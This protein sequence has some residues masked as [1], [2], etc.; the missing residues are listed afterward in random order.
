MRTMPIQIWFFGFSLSILCHF[1][2]ACEVTITLTNDTIQVSGIAEPEMKFIAE[3]FQG[4]TKAIYS[5]HSN[6]IAIVAEIDRGE[7]QASYRWLTMDLSRENSVAIGEV[8][9]TTDR[10]AFESLSVMGDG[11]RLLLAD[12]TNIESS[13]TH[14]I[15]LY[16]N[17]CAIANDSPGHLQRF[18][19]RKTSA[20]QTQ[21]TDKLMLLEKD[22]PIGLKDFNLKNDTTS[23][24]DSPPER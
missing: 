16:Y 1:A 19:R 7:F 10:L 20:E 9:G 5:Y 14:L 8:F 17:N 21:K 11:F 4:T 18:F 15:F 2:F 12:P 24:N 22:C 3:K 6:F 13:G 23:D